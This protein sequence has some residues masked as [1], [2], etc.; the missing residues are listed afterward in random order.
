M[1]SSS[2]VKKKIK[3]RKN[4]II[5]YLIL[6]LCIITFVYL[7]ININNLGVIP[8]K[9][10]YIYY[11]VEI[12]IILIG[13]LLSFPKKLFTFITSIV[14]YILLIFINLFGNYYVHHLNKF[15]DKGFTSEIVET[16]SFYVITSNKNENVDFNSLTLDTKIDYYNIS[17]HNDEAREKLG[18]FD[19]NEIENVNE[20]LYQ[21]KDN[22][23]YLLI[24]DVN[25]KITFELDKKIEEKDYK[26]IY[27]FDIK[28]SEKRNNEVKDSYTILVMGKDFSRVRN[29]LNMLITINTITH[30]ML[31]TNIP[32]DYYIPTVGYKY[33]D[34]LMVMGVLGD[35]T[36]IKSIESYFGI[37]I[38]YKINL[39]TEN[40][41]DIVDE[42]GG[43]EFC[44]DFAFTTTHALVQGTYDDRQGK[45]LRVKKGCQNLNGIETLTVA[46]ER[47]AYE[48]G[49]R[50]RQVN[51]GKIMVS[52]LK[53]IANLTTLTNYTSIL[54]SFSNFYKTNIN[55]NTA[56]VL[57]RNVINNGGYEIIQQSVDG[58][59]GKEPLRQNTSFSDILYPD[60]E[61]VKKASEKINEIINEK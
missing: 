37:T 5:N 15:I 36:V 57:I 54:D 44:S 52:I 2:N 42:I 31:I 29:D 23:F 16:T 28:T 35:D 13:F 14:L 7:S 41:V 4:I 24:D 33:K 32:R 10:L 61:T 48:S 18:E 8:D 51:C 38:D 9:Y 43:I 59:G 26:I 49:D 40:L 17:R 3:I 46:R 20:Y 58:E 50:Q 56:V 30:K 39:Y 27:T 11:I 60:E 55:R 19:Y 53:K 22:N 45:K 1:N 34:S 47:L 25:Y 12:V 6:A 21:N